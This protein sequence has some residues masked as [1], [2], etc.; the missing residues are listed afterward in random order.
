MTPKLYHPATFILS[1]SGSSVTF[2]AIFA[3]MLADAIS[4]KVTQIL[5]DEYTYTLEMLYPTSG[6]LSGNISCGML[7]QAKPDKQHSA[8]YFEIY[9]IAI[10]ID[11]VMKIYAHH[12]SYLL[13]SIPVPAFNRNIMATTA[14]EKIQTTSSALVPHTFKLNRSGEVGS[15][16][17]MNLE[18]PCSVRA[19]IIGTDIGFAKLF[20]GE[21][22]FDNFD[23]NVKERIGEDTSAVIRYGLNMTD[24]EQDENLTNVYTGIYPYAVQTTTNP[25]TGESVSNVVTPG[26]VIYESSDPAYKKVK[27][28][29]LTD[30]FYENGVSAEITV[31]A[32]LEAANEYIDENQ[33][34]VS[35]LNI[36]VSFV[37]LDQ[38]GEYEYTGGTEN[39]N[40]GDSLTVEYP[41][42]GITASAR[43]VKTVFD[44]FTERY[45]SIEVGKVKRTIVDTILDLKRDIESNR[46]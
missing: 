6:R 42:V 38:S 39:V 10:P 33:W 2:S 3:G 32:V 24:F 21:V 7:I 11:G 16:K 46:R 12:I 17:V 44:V 27:V 15:G 28:I 30:R 19:A 13:S 14:L 37:P 1:A 4:C 43:C 34:G 45:D 25:S 8:Q 29:D 31:D 18:F 40:L 26:Y 9:R 22:E 20:N 35:N 36:K 23:V 41:A 5:D